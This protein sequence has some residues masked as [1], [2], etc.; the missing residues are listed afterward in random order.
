MVRTVSAGGT[1]GV[2]DWLIAKLHNFSKSFG[3]RSTVMW[4]TFSL[5]SLR[6]YGHGPST[7]TEQNDRAHWSPTSARCPISPQ[8]RRGCESSFVWESFRSGRS[9]GSRI[10]TGTG[11]Q[12]S[13]RTSDRGTR[14]FGN[15]PPFTGPQ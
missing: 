10:S 1:H 7:M 15:P 3:G 8:D 4:P 13:R 5:W 11:T 12:L 9:W 6:R 2:L 14:C